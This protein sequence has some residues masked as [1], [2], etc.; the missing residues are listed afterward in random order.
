MHTYVGVQLLSNRTSVLESDGFV[1]FTL[2]SSFPSD[3]PFTV[4]AFTMDREGTTAESMKYIATV[5]IA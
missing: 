2:V 5:L 1:S 3:D 4:H